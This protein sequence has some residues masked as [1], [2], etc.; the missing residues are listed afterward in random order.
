MRG[1]EL[2]QVD[3]EAARKALHRFCKGEQ[4]MCVPAQNDDDDFLIDKALDELELA[5]EKIRAYE[6]VIKN[7]NE[8]NRQ[9][10]Y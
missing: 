3:I 10:G 4:R 9:H 5:R 1:D 2:Q 8:I 7:Q 6:Q